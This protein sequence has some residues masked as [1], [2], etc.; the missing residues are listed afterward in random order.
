MREIPFKIKFW[1]I[2]FL[3]LLFIFGFFGYVHYHLIMGESVFL[4]LV[5]PRDPLSLLQGHYLVL[6]YEISNLNPENCT[7]YT[8]Y[9]PD[10][11]YFEIGKIVYVTLKKEGNY[12]RCKRIDLYLPQNELF[13]KGK[14]VSKYGCNLNIEYGIE[15]YFIPEKNYQKIEEKLQELVREKEILVEAK[16]NYR[17]EAL[18]KRLIINGE[19]LDLLKLQKE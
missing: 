3:Q 7:F 15:N 9:S 4:K 11:S 1:S 14:I 5:P 8:P 6:N 10:C 17:G 16:V 12:H 19:K 18:I 2:I 13:I